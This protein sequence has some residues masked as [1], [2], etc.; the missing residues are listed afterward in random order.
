MRWAIRSKL[1]RARDLTRFFYNQRVLGFEVPDS[2]Y[3]DPVSTE[4]FLKML[5]ASD[6][7][8]EFGSG[9]ST[10]AASKS[11]VRTI[12]VESDRYFA[13]AVK[14]KIGAGCYNTMLV[15]DTSVT[16][17]WSYPFFTSQT[18]GRIKRW[19]SYIGTP[20][21]FIRNSLERFPDLVLIDGRFRKACALACAARAIDT[22]ASTIICFDDYIDRYWYHEV[23]T[24]LGIPEMIGRMAVFKVLPSNRPIENNVIREAILDPR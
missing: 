15:I 19:E 20:L 1:R 18:R 9:G 8:L 13:R 14:R 7:Y 11:N 2:P 16:V 3:F 5:E 21:E 4:P 23:E 12:T 24:Y 17:E 22:G 6:L 10:V